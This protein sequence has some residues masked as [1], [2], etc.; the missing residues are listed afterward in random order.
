MPRLIAV[1]YRLL[2][3]EEAAACCA[4][5]GETHDFGG[6][7]V[8]TFEGGQ[9]L[10]VSWVGEPVQYAIGFQDST[11][12]LVDAALADFD[13]SGSSMWSSLVGH[14][15]SLKFVASDNQALEVSSAT[16]RLLFCSFE[17]GHW[18][19]DEVTVCRELPAPYDT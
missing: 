19:A 18:W 7:V 17:R 12:F 1:R 3:G 4:E 14:D 2:Q 16:G 10:F 13:V 6:E 8:L 11:H 9:V 15:V 5:S